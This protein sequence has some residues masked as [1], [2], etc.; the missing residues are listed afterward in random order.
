MPSILPHAGFTVDQAAR[1]SGLTQGAGIAVGL[2]VSWLLD[3]WKPGRTMVSAYALVTLA[4]LAMGLAVVAGPAWWTVLLLLA[5]GG[6]SGG[7][8]A[9]PALTAF[10]FPSRLL[11]SAI[12]MGV[13]IARVGAIAAPLI[14]GEMLKAGATPGHVLL[15]AAVPAAICALVCLALPAALAVRKRIEA[16]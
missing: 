16:A 7:A 12:G 11:S 2:L 9:I 3:N 10:L 1:V 8:M 14:G 15:A 4:L 5:M 13:L 6:V